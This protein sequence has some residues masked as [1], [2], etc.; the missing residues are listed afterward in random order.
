MDVANAD[1]YKDAAG[2]LEQFARNNNPFP[3]VG[4]VGVDAEFPRVAISVNLFHFA[5]KVFL[6]V[7]DTFF[8]N[9]GLE[10]GAEVD[11]VR[12]IHVDHLD[13]S[14]QAFAV[15]KGIHR[16]EAIAEDQAI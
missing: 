8:E 15:R 7:A 10:I 3:Q 16:L 6:G 12:R 14:C 13:L 5:G 2:V 4:E 1:L 9:V 11:P